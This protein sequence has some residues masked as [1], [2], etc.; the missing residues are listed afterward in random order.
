MT[1]SM[2]SSSKMPTPLVFTTTSASAAR[3]ITWR[4]AVS[5]ASYTTTR[6]HSGGSMSRCF[7]RS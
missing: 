1:P 2:S 5:L 4:S 3:A 7:C 6:A